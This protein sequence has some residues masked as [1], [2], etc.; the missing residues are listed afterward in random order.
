[1]TSDQPSTQQPSKLDLRP[2]PTR[3]RKGRVAVHLL[4][5]CAVAAGVASA[6]PVSI[7]NP[8]FEDLYLGSNLPAEYAGDVPTGTFPT[9]PAP[10]G[11][12]A[13][14]QGGS[15]PAGA[16]I[17]VL[18]PGTADDFAPDP[19]FFELGAPEGDNAV[20]LYTNGD[21]GGSEYG[22]EQTLAA[23]LEADTLYSL[24]VT[25]G[26]IGS[27]TALLPPYSGFGFYDLDGF[28]GYRVQLLAGGVVVTGDADGVLPAERRWGTAFAA[29]STTDSH[30]QLGETLSIRLVNRNQPD[31]VGVR[32]IEVDFDDV[33][34]DASPAQPVP[35]GPATS[36][37]LLLCVA[38]LGARLARNRSGSGT[39][40]GRDGAG[41]CGRAG[42]T[43][44]CAGSGGPAG[45]TP[46]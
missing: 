44:S 18:N 20:L 10:N 45:S 37:G 28:P 35:I 30:P 43:G 9:G 8:G 38:A 25:V 33:Q 15:P 7:S 12:T 24:R 32:G 16:S 46:A 11:W 29:L 2:P 21:T 3:R 42:R 36:T 23:V 1:M 39:P 31:V 41:R 19:A 14:Y 17:G 22:V 6:A 5:V 40:T 26:N 4:L 27:G 13:Y 34:L